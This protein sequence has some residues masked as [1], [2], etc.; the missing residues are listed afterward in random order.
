MKA[1]QMTAA[2]AAKAKQY[3]ASMKGGGK[4]KMTV[5]DLMGGC[6]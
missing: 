5:S 3:A 2:M 1:K 6:K 4:N